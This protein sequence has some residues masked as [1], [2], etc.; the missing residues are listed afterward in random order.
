MPITQRLYNTPG[1]HGQAV[2]AETYAREPSWNATRHNG[3]ANGQL[4]QRKAAQRWHSITAPASARE[5]LFD[6]HA[7]SQADRY[8][9]NIERYIG[10]VKI[11]LGLAGP[12]RVNGDHASG[13]YRIPLATTEAALVASY[14]RGA[15]VITAAGGCRSAIVQKG[16]SRS[17]GFVFHNLDEVQRFVYWIN[18]S[19]TELAAVVA[20]NSRYTRLLK[21]TPTIE[22]NHVYLD[23]EFATGDAAGQNMATFSAESII[24]YIVDHAPVQ[25]RSYL[26]EAN[27]SG[28]KKATARA[29]M[30]VRGRRVS[31]EVMIPAE[32][33]QQG[34]RTT[35]EKMVD[36][37]RLCAIGSSLSG[38]L[39][40]QGHI[41]NGL[42]A[43]YLACGQDVA[44]VAEA[45]V[46]LTRFE[47]TSDGDLYACVTLPALVIGTVGGGT[48][49]PSQQA[50]LEILGLAGC[51]H[52]DA[53]AELCAGLV[54]AGE[55]S[56]SAALSAH[57]FG[58]AHHRLARAPL[59][60]HD[61]R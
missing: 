58:G 46:G 3:D 23:C 53:F 14:H 8:A 32:L 45:S 6:S 27:L 54:L 36:C 38:S 34:L 10:T 11:P 56:I 51:G 13:E 33:V 40:F 20:A 17:P 42:A 39:G 22:G 55:I 49:L 9:N 57:E 5:E 16:I 43:L 28:D 4:K 30:S 18:A 25:P 15:R 29:F 35:V 47:Q 2:P 12:L 7:E 44:C 24:H 31:A 37:W 52:A 19:Y 61:A 41:A 1:R 26:L 21:I 59:E 48:G 50:C 60:L